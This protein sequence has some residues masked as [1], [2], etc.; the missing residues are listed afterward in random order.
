MAQV[1]GM[2]MIFL[3]KM[4]KQKAYNLMRRPLEVLGGK[5]PP[6]LL[7]VQPQKTQVHGPDLNQLANLVQIPAI[8][9]L[10]SHRLDVA[11]DLKNP[12]PPQT[13]GEALKR[14][15]VL[16]HLPC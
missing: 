2:R 15:S 12:T 14:M 3:Q 11:Q 1:F 8:A 5:G 6:M 16:P 13:L 10:L 9:E 7:F 4:W